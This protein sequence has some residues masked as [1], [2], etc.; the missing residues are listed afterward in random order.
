MG[1][2]APPPPLG[3]QGARGPPGR[4]PPPGGTSLCVGVMCGGATGGSDG[5]GED[6]K[7]EEGEEKK[8]PLRPHEEGYKPQAGWQM[9]IP[10]VAASEFAAKLCPGKKGNSGWQPP[11]APPVPAALE[12]LET[13]EDLLRA[14]GL[15]QPPPKE[16]Q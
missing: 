2:H 15:P 9:M 8:K 13:A 1:A 4:A 5:T 12:K 10:L 11:P 16:E 3:E 14:L 7:K 6:E